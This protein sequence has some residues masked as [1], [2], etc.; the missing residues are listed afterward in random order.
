MKLLTIYCPNGYSITAIEGE[1][2]VRLIEDTSNGFPEVTI[3]YDNGDY[4]C[5]VGMPFII[6]YEVKE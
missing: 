2:G 3:S 6:A 5:Y 1:D 4:E